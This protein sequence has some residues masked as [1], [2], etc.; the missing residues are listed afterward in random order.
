MAGIKITNF[1]GKAP[2]VSPELLP[3]TAAQIAQNCKLYSGDLIPYPQPTVVANTARTGTIKTLYAL[4]NPANPNDLKWLSWNTEVSIGSTTRAT[5]HP[6]SATT[7][8]RQRAQSRTRLGITISACPYRP[9]L[10][11]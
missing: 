6:R 2:K 9:T 5:A 1:L 8:W 10:R 11:C 4:R 7:I 3:N